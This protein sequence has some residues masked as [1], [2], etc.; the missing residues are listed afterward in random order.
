MMRLARDCGTE[1]WGTERSVGVELRVE[2]EEMNDWTREGKR[3]TKDE[4]QKSD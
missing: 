1:I 3:E 2:E 4:M